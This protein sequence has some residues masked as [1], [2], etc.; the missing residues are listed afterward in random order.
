MVK[1]ST[2]PRT[3][4][5]NETQIERALI[6]YIKITFFIE[7]PNSVKETWRTPFPSVTSLHQFAIQFLSS[8]QFS[9][10]Q[11]INLQ[12]GGFLLH[13]L[14]LYSRTRLQKPFDNICKRVMSFP[15]ASTQ[16]YMLT[17]WVLLVVY[18]PL[19]KTHRSSMQGFSGGPVVKS[20]P[21]NAEDTDSIPGWGRSHM[22]QSN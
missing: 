13:P 3:S 5:G 21:C 18:P 8:L 15:Q 2:C 20:L 7:T 12:K 4:L 9:V 14:S 17:C 1:K 16:G 10:H 11:F 19:S 6:S 22:P